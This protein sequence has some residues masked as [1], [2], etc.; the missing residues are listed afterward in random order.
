MAARTTTIYPGTG[1]EMAKLVSKTAALDEGAGKVL[2]AAQAIA[3]RHTRTGKYAAS[4][5]VG[6][7]R[8]KGVDD[9]IVYSDDPAAESIEFGHMTR[10]A[11]GAVGPLRWVPGL[12]ILG[13]AMAQ[14][15]S[16]L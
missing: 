3:A 6:T 8:H 7:E 1:T 2:A 14:A 11:K 4:L 15:E 12:R 9:R 5:K 13:R 10:R 16:G